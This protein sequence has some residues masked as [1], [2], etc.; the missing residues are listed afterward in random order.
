MLISICQFKTNTDL[1]FTQSL[2]DSSW[3]RPE[4]K[5]RALRIEQ[6]IGIVRLT[7]SFEFLNDSVCVTRSSSEAEGAEDEDAVV[8]TPELRLRHQ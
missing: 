7:V 4:I 5:R 8:G 2:A 6:D 1:A 3:H